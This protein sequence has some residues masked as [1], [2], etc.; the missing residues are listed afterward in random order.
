MQRAELRAYKVVDKYIL[1]SRSYVPYFQNLF[2]IGESYK[3]DYLENPLPFND[4]GNKITKD[5]TVLIVSR[6]SEVQK[7]Y[8]VSIENMEKSRKCS[9]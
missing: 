8:K 5:K 2:G 3:L 9:C 4:T 1:L 7:K 6:F